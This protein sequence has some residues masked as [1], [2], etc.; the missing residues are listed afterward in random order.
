M[1]ST[2]PTASSTNS[3][4]NTNK[5]KDTTP[6]VKL[7]LKLHTLIIFILS[8]LSYA[9]SFFISNSISYGYCNKSND[10]L[11]SKPSKKTVDNIDYMTCKNK[12]KYKP[13]DF[14]YIINIFILPLAIPTIIG[15]IGYLI[16]E[17]KGNKNRIYFD[18]EFIINILLII[19]LIIQFILYIIYKKSCMQHKYECILKSELKMKDT[20]LGYVE[21]N[22]VPNVHILSNVNYNIVKLTNHILKSIT[23]FAVILTFYLID[24]QILIPDNAANKISTKINEK[25]YIIITTIIFIINLL[26]PN[27][28][29]QYI[30]NSII[31]FISIV[32][33]LC[34]GYIFSQTTLKFLKLDNICNKIIMLAP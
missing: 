4:N 18:G 1:P 27:T 24:K 10:E 26:L 5:P 28:Y 11:C 31:A 14:T 7:N 21:Y 9:L 19:V 17:Y 3:G 12:N 30:I 13:F 16:Y 22:C 25:F 34:Y 33:L 23:I 15:S 32:Y 8:I 2:S 29:T 6:H 20:S